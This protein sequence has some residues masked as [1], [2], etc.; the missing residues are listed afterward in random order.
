MNTPWGKADHS[1]RYG[2]GS[3]SIYVMFYSTPSHGGF[4]VTK[5]MEARMPSG[6]AAIKTYA[7]ENAIGKWYEEDCNWAIVALAFPYLFDAKDVF[8]AVEGGNMIWRGYDGEPDKEAMPEVR[9]WLR[10][11]E[12]AKVCEI[13]A[14]YELE[15]GMKFRLGCQSTGGKG[16]NVS[17]SRID[18]KIHLS[19]YFPDSARFYDLPSPFTEEQAREYGGEILK[20]DE[21][22]AA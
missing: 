19:I 13:A 14:R 1:K 7:G 21:R 10:S 6:L 15:N 3:A 11:A 8:A 9:A 16:W 12:G 2:S 4:L 22:R 17:A 20:R 5:D 18:N